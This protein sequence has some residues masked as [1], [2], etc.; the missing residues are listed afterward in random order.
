MG[1]SSSVPGQLDTP[2]SSRSGRVLFLLSLLFPSGFISKGFTGV[3]CGIS[4][5]V[6]SGLLNIGDGGGRKS[7]V[8]RPVSLFPVE[9]IL[10]YY[11][12]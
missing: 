11:K 8:F 10:I 6:S 4:N 5:S 7:D 2:S 12:Y 1:T 3:S 9:K